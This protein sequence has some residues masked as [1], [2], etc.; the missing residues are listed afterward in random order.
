MTNTSEAY[1]AGPALREWVVNMSRP[2]ARHVLVTLTGGCMVAL[3]ALTAAGAA[4]RMVTDGVGGVFAVA[5]V[6]LALVDFRSSV[7]VAIFE[8][9]LGGASGHW[10]DYGG[11]LTGRIFLDG[12]VTL[13][14]VGITVRDW[15]KGRRPLLGR[16]G[17]HA[18]AIALLIPAIWIPLGLVDGNRP[19]DVVADGDGFLFFAFVLVVVT[20]IR[21]GEGAWLRRMFFAACA[22]SGTT[23]F[24]LVVATKSGVLGLETVREW[25]SVRL[26]MGGVIGYMPNGDYRL[27][28][29]GSLFLQVGLV[30]TTQRLLVRPHHVRL[31]L[32][33]GVFGV[34][35]VATYTRGLW[36]AALVSAVC[37]L[38]LQARSV[39]QL[40]FAVAIPAAVVALAL[41]AASLAG[42]SPYGYVAARASTIV[43]ASQPRYHTH[44]TNP[45]F[46]TSTSGWGVSNAGGGLRVLQTG[47]ASRAGPHSL[48]LSNSSAAEDAYVFQNLGVKPKEKYSVSAWV[49]ARGL[50]HPAAGGR[51][52][53]VW[54]PQDGLVYTVPLTSRTNGWRRLSFTFQTRAKT[55]DDIQIRLYAPQG[56]VLWDGVQV[57]P[58]GAART[59]LGE[60]PPVQFINPRPP[61]SRTAVLDP[62]FARAG[63]WRVSDAGPRPL[64]VRRTPSAGRAGT[65]SL[66]LSN[67]RP[68]RDAFVFQN[69]TV[70]PNTQYAVSAWVNARGLRQPA[71]GGRAGRGL[72]VW[73]AQDG[74]VYT[75]PLTS[76][77]HGWRR[78]SLPFTTRANARY[79]QIRLYAPKG[80]VLWDGVH[81]S[82][83]GTL[84]V[85]SSAATPAAQ[86]MALA[87]TG[88]G[89]AD[90][91]GEASNAYRIAEAKALLRYIR[92]RPIYGYGFGTIASNFSTGYSY[93]LSYLD[94]LLKTG[95]LGLL[96]YLSF[97]LRLI[98]DALRLRRR[99]FGAVADGAK[100]IGA[101]GVVVGVV[102]GILLAGATNPYLFAAFG[103]VSMLAMVAWLEGPPEQRLAVQDEG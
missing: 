27:F 51:G 66:Q 3:A 69:L 23:Y 68:G 86:T 79:I 7:G 53:L 1:A 15:R 74:L 78:L 77:T 33:A 80:R 65:P 10:V 47:S 57:A 9:V 17:A 22:T 24:L 5:F 88:E 98:V 46:E 52:L 11:G 32:L 58:R 60:A 26:A 2:H 34:D 8:L 92:R 21:R 64:R 4:S 14:A 70:A 95:I 101:R 102:V 40:G 103:L 85:S 43:S 67:S 90:I 29:A 12:V 25:L 100:A 30:L 73:D 87:S 38:A 35:L 97:P 83:G 71:A 75:V 41:A 82:A 49:N 84:Q 55:S 50:R 20:L 59:V 36:L 18:L 62:G 89:A 19:R 6:A 42:F 39:K 56:R 31:W 44:V 61:S 28:T 13:G 99:R 94:L 93:E 76:R 81:L 37:V 54:D 63:V 16:Y 96:L 48:E 91:A 72:L 45:S